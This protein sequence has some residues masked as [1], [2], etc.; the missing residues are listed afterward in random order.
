MRLFIMPDG[1]NI[2]DE[3]S[4]DRFVD[5]VVCERCIEIDYDINDNNG[6]SDLEQQRYLNGLD[7]APAA[8]Y[9]WLCGVGS[10]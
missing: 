6:M 1:K 2:G 7:V 4:G 10:A 3:T 9:C 5:A 8:S